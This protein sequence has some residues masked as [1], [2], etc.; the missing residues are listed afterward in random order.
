MTSN[1]KQNTTI[2]ITVVFLMFSCQMVRK[3]N[4]KKIIQEWYGKEILIPT[5]IEYRILGRDTASSA[6]W[7][8]PYKIFNYID[9]I[10]CSSCQ[11]GL[12]KWKMLIDSCN[13]QQLDV[14]I[15][16]VIHSS[17]YDLLSWDLKE[18]HFNHPVIYDYNNQF[19]KLNHFPPVPYRTFLLDKD[20]KVK[21]IGSPIDSPQIWELYKKE[22]KQQ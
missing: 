10:G 14:G 11:L 13:L 22:I 2:I 5:E 19:D 16:F 1:F 12:F 21:L 18:N 6:L 4:I 15:L 7:D 3:E 20:N 9:S 8:R 17:D